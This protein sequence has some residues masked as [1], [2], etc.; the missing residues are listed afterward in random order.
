MCIRDRAWASRAPDTDDDDGHT[1]EGTP[2]QRIQVIK[3]WT[4]DSGEAHEA[5]YDI[6]DNPDNG[7]SVDE[8]TCEPQGSGHDELCAVWTDPDFD[9]DERASY[10]T[11]VLENPS[12]RY[13]GWVC[14]ENAGEYDCSDE[15]GEDYWEGC[16]DADLPKTFQE[17]AW[18]SPIWYAP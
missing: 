5:V 13:S 12:C 4:D 17:R 16:C 9:P 14:M 10:Y 7:A 18:T 3:V 2:L 11:R 15:D 6:T 8:D 1:W